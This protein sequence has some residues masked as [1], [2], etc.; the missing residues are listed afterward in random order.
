MSLYSELKSRRDI[1]EQLAYLM[2]IAR[3][4][5]PS[6]VADVIGDAYVEIQR[7]N[8]NV[9]QLQESKTGEELLAEVSELK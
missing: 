8:D 5:Y 9:Q 3:A 7:L 1:R 6:C 4:F 2:P